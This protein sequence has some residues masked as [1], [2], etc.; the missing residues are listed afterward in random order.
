MNKPVHRISRRALLGGIGAGILGVPFLSRMPSAEAQVFPTRFVVFF[1]PNESI[2][3]Q[4]WQPGANMALK[5]MMQPLTPYKSKLNIIGDLEFTSRLDDPHPGGH[6]GIGHVLIG[7]RV[8][9][10]GPNEG[11]H[12]AGG[13]S[14]DQYI[15]DQLGVD[16]L[17]VGAR[18]GSN[19]GNSRLSYTGPNQ[20]VQP[21][22]DP[23]KAFN[24]V[25]GNY[26]V[27]PDVLA[28]MNAQKRSVLDTVAGHLD[29][30][31][32]RVS[33]ADQDKLAVHLDR[34]RELELKLQQSQAVTCSPVAPAGGYS[35]TS[36]ADYP[37]IGRRHMDVVAQALACNVTR[38]ATIQLGNSG[39]SHITPA[40]P[41]EGIDIN[42]DAHNIS[43]NYN[44][45]QDAL[46]TDRRVQLETWY[47][48]QFAYLLQKLDEVPE[49]SGTLLD[50]TLVLWCKPIGRRHSV[51]E[52][53]FMLAGS[54]GGQLATGRYLSFDAMPH[55]N[56]LT[57]CCQLMGL[58]DQSFG[59][60]NYCTG[61]LAL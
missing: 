34:V 33:A 28:E 14:V 6:I 42:V 35:Y 4:F 60:G 16:P 38:V 21:I 55:N 36:N 56:L 32:T 24:Q 46:N 26:A 52:M 41:S 17:V 39:T 9:P 10:F 19:S 8:I 51:N 3:K 1:T 29:G 23:M 54:A 61:P 43:H 11:D 37:I 27:P 22:E 53:L 31:K 57:S 47:Y 2:D 49:G 25:L 13:I 5:P 44:N 40:W 30:I 15:A 58:G 59:D 18:V 45:A 20:P 12:F 48:K 50:N 7:R